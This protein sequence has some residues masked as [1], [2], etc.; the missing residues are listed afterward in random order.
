[1]I[2]L[3]MINESDNKT[4]K[5]FLYELFYDLPNRMTPVF[6][7]TVS[8]FRQI[9]KFMTFYR[10]PDWNLMSELTTGFPP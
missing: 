9:K 5:D 10:I 2:S 8:V 6:T 7:K 1:M 3:I 4:E